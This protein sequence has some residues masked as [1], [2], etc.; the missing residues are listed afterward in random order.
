MEYVAG[1]L[2]SNLN[3]GQKFKGKQGEEGGL[4]QMVGDLLNTLAQQVLSAAGNALRQKFRQ[5]EF[6]LAAEFCLLRLLLHTGC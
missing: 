6:R 5:D 1:I 3:M 2:I 4:V